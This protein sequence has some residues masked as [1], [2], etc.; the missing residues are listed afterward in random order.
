MAGRQVHVLPPLMERQRRGEGIDNGQSMQ[1]V[2]DGRSGATR[3]ACALS[4]PEQLSE[5]KDAVGGAL[6]RFTQVRHVHTVCRHL[7]LGV[8]RS[9]VV[10]S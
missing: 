7:A 3:A 8:Q 1:P 6:S 10:T 4:Y 5:L 9:A 2:L